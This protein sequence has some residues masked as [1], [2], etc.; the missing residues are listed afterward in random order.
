MTIHLTKDQKANLKGLIQFSFR[1]TR[2][3]VI[4]C[5]RTDYENWIVEAAAIW[6]RDNGYNST[7]FSE[8]CESYIQSL[9]QTVLREE[10]K[11]YSNSGEEI[12]RKWLDTIKFVKES[13]LIA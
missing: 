8:F 3:G 10:V 4:H 7:G 13:K 5:L 11:D 1:M 9:N 6:V 2:P 12:F